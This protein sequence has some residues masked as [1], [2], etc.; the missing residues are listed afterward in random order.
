M[1]YVPTYSAL[2][3]MS[4]KVDVSY[5]DETPA[6]VLLLSFNAIEIRRFIVSNSFNLIHTPKMMFRIDSFNELCDEMIQH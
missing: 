4:D 5:P 3:L 2:N 6:L 1:L